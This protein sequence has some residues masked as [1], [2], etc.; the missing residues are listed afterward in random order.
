M[1]ANG[2]FVSY[3]LDRFMHHA[4]NRISPDYLHLL[5]EEDRKHIAH[6]EKFI[7]TSSLEDKLL[8]LAKIG[9]PHVITVGSRRSRF[10]IKEVER[11]IKLFFKTITFQRK[12]ASFILKD[13]HFFCIGDID[14]VRSLML[15]SNL[16]NS[17]VNQYNVESDKMYHY[18]KGEA[19]LAK[20]TSAAQ[21][22]DNLIA[23]S[24]RLGANLTQQEQFLAL[25][26]ICYKKYM[27]LA[28]ISRTRESTLAYI[29]RDVG[30]HIRSE[31]KELVQ[32]GMIQ[33]K[34]AALSNTDTDNNKSYWITGYGELVLMKARNYF[35]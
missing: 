21:D 14:I 13:H 35:L 5:T 30:F 9:Y 10:S 7:A 12:P 26:K 15:S 20:N 33:S 18:K 2:A 8:L 11:L 4:I 19:N 22:L 24:I 28:H 34:L 31:L 27:I 29:R 1:K 6:K 16:H 17:A 3:H 23:K 25:Y 32:D